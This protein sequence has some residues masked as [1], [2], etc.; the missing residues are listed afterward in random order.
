MIPNSQHFYYQKFTPASESNYVLMSS[1]LP[2][3]KHITGHALKEKAAKERFLKVMDLG[4]DHA[5]AGMYEVRLSAN[6]DFVGLAK[7]TYLKPNEIEIGYS[8]FEQYWGQGWGTE[9]ALHLVTFAQ[10]FPHITQAIGIIDPAN[11]ASQRILEKC[12]FRFREMKKMHGINSAVYIL[13]INPH[14]KDEPR[15]TK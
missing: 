13:S 14:P 15:N 3:M 5:E 7:F 9:I 8:L 4:K 6:N 10:Q 11:S 1:S 2:V 12:G